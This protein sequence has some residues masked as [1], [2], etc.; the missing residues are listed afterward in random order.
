[1]ECVVL[2]PDL[3]DRI[4]LLSIHRE[5]SSHAFVENRDNRPLT[6]TFLNVFQTV[7]LDRVYLFSLNY[8]KLINFKL[9]F[10]N[11]NFKLKLINFKLFKSPLC[12]RRYPAPVIV[13]L[14]KLKCAE[15]RLGR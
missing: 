1:M 8:L 13:D 11:F 5:Q 15:A 6:P 4:E 14:H 2:Y 12:F 9:K 7:K 10:I 3:K